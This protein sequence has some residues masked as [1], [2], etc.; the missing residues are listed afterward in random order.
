MDW[1]SL[2]RDRFRSVQLYC[3]YRPHVFILQKAN[4]VQLLNYACSEEQ[5][6]F[7][8]SKKC[9]QIRSNW[10]TEFVMVYVIFRRLC[11]NLFHV[12]NSLAVWSKLKSKIIKFVAFSTYC[13]SCKI[14]IVGKCHSVCILFQILIYI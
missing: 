11:E 10:Y 6:F 3:R 14:C 9:I 7:F 13:I 8:P 12:H 2:P 5:I 1:G 4:L